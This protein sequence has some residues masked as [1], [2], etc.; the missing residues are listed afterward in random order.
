MIFLV[1]WVPVISV[2]AKGIHV[3]KDRH[4]SKLEEYCILAADLKLLRSLYLIL[5][6]SYLNQQL[7][8]SIIIMS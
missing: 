7:A 5:C 6:A 3:A 2:F 8:S 1:L 4:S